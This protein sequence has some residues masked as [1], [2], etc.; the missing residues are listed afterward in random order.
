MGKESKRS[1]RLVAAAAIAVGAAGTAVAQPAP[2][3]GKQAGDFVVGV[4]GIGVLPT[5]GGRVDAIGGRPE[6]SNSGT[7][8]LDFSYFL[9]PQV[10]LNLIAATTQHDVSVRNS[11]AS[12]RNCSGARRRR[13]SGVC[14]VSSSGV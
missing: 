4:G 11:S 8:Q 10:A 1:L 2:V 7:A 5:N 12:C 14:T 6:A 3:R 13:S 9:A